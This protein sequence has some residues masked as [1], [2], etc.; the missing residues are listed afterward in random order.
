MTNN[1]KAVTHSLEF[2]TGET[3]CAYEY[4]KFCPFLKSKNFGTVYICG[5]F[6]ETLAENDQGCIE[7][8][9]ECLYKFV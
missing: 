4:G 6:D 1:I 3:T 7:R 5:Y 8:C 9:P 2:K